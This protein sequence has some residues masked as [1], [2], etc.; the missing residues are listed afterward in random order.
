MGHVRS[1]FT[2][3]AGQWEEPSRRALLS[4][5]AARKLRGKLQFSGG[6]RKK[7][8]P[9]VKSKSS[10]TASQGLDQ[11][12]LHRKLKTTQKTTQ[13]T[14]RGYQPPSTQ[15]TSSTQQHKST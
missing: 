4:E 15:L 10:G 11:E 5:L 3:T 8:R 7:P 14:L 9:Q 2:G 1:S 12:E 6:Q 13:G